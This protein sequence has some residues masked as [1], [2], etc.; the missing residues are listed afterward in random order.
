MNQETIRKFLVK[1]SSTLKDVIDCLEK[2]R[3]GI[4]VVV[5]EDQRFLGYITDGDIRRSYI[6]DIDLSKTADYLLNHPSL[7]PLHKTLVAS[8]EESDAERLSTM[9]H[10]DVR[11]LPVLDE[12]RRLVDLAVLRD[13]LGE[14][15]LKEVKAVIMAG[16]YG[17][18][19]EELT[20]NTPKPML[21]VGDK[22]LL[23]N[24]VTQLKDVGI[25]KLEFTTHYKASIISEHFGDGEHFGVDIG[26]IEEESPLG[27]A[28]SLKMVQDD[29]APML[30][31]NG[32]IV[33][34]VDYKALVD[35]HVEHKADITISV[36]EY[37][38][39]VPYGVVESKGGKVQKI[40][41]KPKVKFF[42]NAGI[43]VV[44]HHVKEL[45]PDNVRFDMTDLIEV[46][47]Q[48]GLTIASFPII[49]YWLDI[50]NIRDYERA[51]R[52]FDPKSQDAS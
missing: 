43:Y 11:H 9:R 25:G 52:E 15:H 29:R 36:R 10:N 8:P 34:S 42:V 5:D 31:M 46:C 19:L 16:G 14:K 22:P 51:V 37:D 12:N 20:I 48:K 35:Y 2:N 33:T 44:E 1:P 38:F 17:R 23:E 49:E 13:L 45:I 24:I 18:R 27:T 4:A 28:G 32:D 3:K 47:M 40:T 7:N 26:Y 39:E 21:S 41:E 30:V 6:N 50:G